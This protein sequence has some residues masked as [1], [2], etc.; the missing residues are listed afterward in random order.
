[1]HRLTINTTGESV[2]ELT[3]NLRRILEKIQQGETEYRE[4]EDEL[5]VMRFNLISPDDYKKDKPK[6]A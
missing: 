3:R 6:A 5:A 1:M 2:Q 4:S